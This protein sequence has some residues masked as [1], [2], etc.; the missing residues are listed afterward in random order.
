MPSATWRI[1]VCSTAQN[2]R[3]AGLLGALLRKRQARGDAV[4]TDSEAARCRDLEGHAD[5]SRAGLRPAK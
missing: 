3:Q 1:D 5:T 2:T 4:K